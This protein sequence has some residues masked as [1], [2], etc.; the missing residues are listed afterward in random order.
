MLKKVK[1]IKYILYSYKDEDYEEHKDDS[2]KY[3]KNLFN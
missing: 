1:I 3:K 2:C